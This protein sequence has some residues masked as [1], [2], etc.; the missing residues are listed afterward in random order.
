MEKEVANLLAE[1]I[2]NPTED[3][4]H[5]LIDSC[6]H[7]KY[8]AM[9][10]ASCSS[11]TVGA[12]RVEAQDRSI[13]TIS[14]IATHPDLRKRGIGRALI[15]F[16]RDELKFEWIEAETDD[17]SL[18]FYKSCSFEIDPLG[19]NNFGVKRYKSKLRC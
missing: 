7:G 6:T 5:A 4:I 11:K 15:E 9:W 16:I 8:P 19:K 2:G 3:S 18:N 10:I 14:H 13:C 17:E 1:S 12:V